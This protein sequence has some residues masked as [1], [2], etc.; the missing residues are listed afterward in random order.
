[1]DLRTQ[2][3]LE[4]ADRNR[5]LAYQFLKPVTAGDLSPPP[6]EWVAVIGFY[7]AVHLVN[8]YCWETHRLDPG[9]HTNRS[10]EV[11]GHFGRAVATSYRL[12]SDRG[13]QARYAPSYQLDGADA[14]ELLQIDLE[15]VRDT[16]LKA[17]GITP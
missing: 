1:M 7:S 12:L 13:W 2:Q 14:Q 9:N 17:L 16:V 15:A 4:R 5:N 10:S 3:H 8:A 6:F 11:T